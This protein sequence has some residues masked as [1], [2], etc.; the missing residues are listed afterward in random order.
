MIE[1]SRENLYYSLQ[2]KFKK[3]KWYL[4][5]PEIVWVTETLTIDVGESVG[6]DVG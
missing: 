2:R 4:L 1:C 6:L 3:Y 5:L